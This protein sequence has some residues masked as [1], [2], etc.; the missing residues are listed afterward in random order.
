MFYS[1]CAVCF[2]KKEN[3]NQFMVPPRLVSN[4]L[5][6]SQMVSKMC[7]QRGMSLG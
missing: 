2:V 1:M 5:K 4:G 6:W 7:R 3:D